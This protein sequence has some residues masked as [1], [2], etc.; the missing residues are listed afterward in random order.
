MFPKRAK[1]DIKAVL[2]AIVFL[3]FAAEP[4]LA[5]DAPAGTPPAVPSFFLFSDTQLIYWHQFSGAEPRVG[6]PIQKN[7]LSIAHFDSWKYGTN[8]ISIDL[9]KSDK[10]DPAAPWGGPG[11]PI[12]AGGIGE[13]AFEF[14]G[15]FRSTLS[16]NA[17]T[18]SNRFAYGPI[19]DVSFYFG[20][21]EETKNTAF[22]PRKRVL[23]GAL[24]FTFD[25]PGAL[26]IAAG[27]HK[28]RFHNGFVPLLGFPPGTRESGTFDAAPTLEAFY[29]HPL[30][31]ILN[32]APVRFSGLT[33]VVGPKGK[34]GFGNPTK[35]EFLTDNRLTLDLGQW[36]AN[37][38]NRIDL[39][40]GWRYW[41][42]KFGLD[43]KLDRTGGTTE[44]TA[45]LGLALHPF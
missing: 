39:F 1:A 20:A 40:A 9:F 30:A 43:P 33:F 37:K 8:L 5:I 21:D 16:L 24:Q 35:T 45:Y 26:T 4:S 11:F 19:K 42:N 27:L 29:M 36:V 44:S 22:A 38:P 2:L 6:K 12:P 3:T 31:S 41:Q 32:G 15:F 28:E 13:G 7:I 18:D 10:H 14:Y 25:V 34:D 23:V 17:L